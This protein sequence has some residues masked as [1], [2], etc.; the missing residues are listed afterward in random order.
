[1]GLGMVSSYLVLH[2][3]PAFLLL[4]GVGRRDW[5]ADKMGPNRMTGLVVGW[6]LHPKK[7]RGLSEHLLQEKEVF[8]LSS[9]WG[10]IS[11]AWE[12][13][14]RHWRKWYQDCASQRCLASWVTRVK[15]MTAG[16][17]TLYPCEACRPARESQSSLEP[18]RGIAILGLALWD[19]GARLLPSHLHF[20][21]GFRLGLQIRVQEYVTYSREL[22]S[23]HVEEIA[24]CPLVVYIF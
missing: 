10:I 3:F 2:P 11:R 8:F 18:Q 20:C 13:I 9:S 14:F 4:L 19:L 12:W 7:P 21:L 1:M 17:R 5:G 15:E 16:A 22:L 24:E 23:G 6:E